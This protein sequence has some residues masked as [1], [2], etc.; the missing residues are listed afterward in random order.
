MVCSS[1]SA[2][3]LSVVMNMRWNRNTLIFNFVVL[4]SLSVLSLSVLSYQNRAAT[5]FVPQR[6]ASRV[7]VLDA[8]HGGED[9]GAVSVT[10]AYESH[11]N[12][13]IALKMEQLCGLF[14]VDVVMVRTEDCSLK[15]ANA[16]TL[17]EM[18]RSDLKNRVNLINST[19]T[20]V[21]ISIH[22]NYFAGSNQ[23][24]QVFYA[25]TQASKAWAKHCQTTLVTSL[26][27]Q[28]HRQSKQITKDIYLMNH[29]DCPA[30][31]VECG[32]LSDKEE[33]VRLETGIYQTKLA[34]TILNSYMTYSFQ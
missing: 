14:G 17:A 27:P 24:A 20:A 23:G 9:G 12:L 29:I 3:K 26:D 22:Q 19:P 6:F 11:I 25:P 28:N 13:A 2:H 31:L 4:F 15:D 10:G 16:Q 30:I 34:L 33:A 21:L 7:L 18:K 1:P 32:F 8:G 5:C